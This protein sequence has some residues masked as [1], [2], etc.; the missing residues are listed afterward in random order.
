MQAFLSLA[1]LLSLATGLRVPFGPHVSASAMRAKVTL[2]YSKYSKESRTEPLVE[3]LAAAE[4]SAETLECLL[5]FNESPAPSTASGPAVGNGFVYGA[6]VAPGEISAEE[7]RALL[8]ATG[9]TRAEC[10]ASAENA[11]EIEEC[12]AD[13][14]ETASD[15]DLI[16]DGLDQIIADARQEREAKKAETD[17]PFP[18]AFVAALLFVVGISN[19]M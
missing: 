14:Q 15:E 9:A 8:V 16:S 4:N 17:E 18:S 7:R 13:Y 3:C 19:F 10:L 11:M 5:P 1:C 2:R 12:Y 6:K